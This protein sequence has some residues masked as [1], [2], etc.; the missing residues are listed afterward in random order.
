MRT[1][2]G[3]AML[4]WM[5]LASGCFRAVQIPTAEPERIFLASYLQNRAV[6]IEAKDPS[7]GTRHLLVLRVR[8]VDVAGAF[9]EGVVRVDYSAFESTTMMNLWGEVPDAR[10]KTIRVDFADM[11]SLRVLGID[12]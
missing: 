9:L 1:V 2:P 7:N 3:I 10:G 5:F 8:R 12:R 6:E 4:S 11:E